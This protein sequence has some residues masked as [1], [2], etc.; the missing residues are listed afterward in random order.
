MLLIKGFIEIKDAYISRYCQSNTNAYFRQ[1]IKDKL[2]QE[3]GLVCPHTK[4][5]G[6]G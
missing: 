3:C 5:L 2:V 6:V 4:F 1:A